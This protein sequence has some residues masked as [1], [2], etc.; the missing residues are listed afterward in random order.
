MKQTLSYAQ[1]LHEREDFERALNTVS[2]SEK[3]LAIHCVANCAGV[4]RLGIVVTKR[5]VPKAV[6]R[7]QIKRLIRE[8]FRMSPHEVGTSFD[9]VVRL[10]KNILAGETIEFRRAMSRLLMKVRKTENGAPVHIDHK[11]LPVSD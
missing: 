7:N 3:W 10:R 2:V 6:S 4:E 1:R 8:I 11:G 9:V 5:K